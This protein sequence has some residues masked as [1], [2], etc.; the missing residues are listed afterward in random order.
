MSAVTITA[1]MPL[2][3]RR[4]ELLPRPGHQREPLHRRVLPQEP[5]HQ[6]GHQRELLLQ[7]GRQQGLLL[8]TGHQQELLLQHTA[9]VPGVA[10]AMVEVMEAA[11]DQAAD[12]VVADTA[13]PQEVGCPEEAAAAEGDAR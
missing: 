3:V 12:T 7:P 8:Q 6:R 13:A 9:E 11:P 4:Q 5:P 2:P 10:E 1:V